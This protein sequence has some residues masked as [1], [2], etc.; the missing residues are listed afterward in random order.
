M[1]NFSRSQEWCSMWQH[2]A[3]R[4]DFDQPLF[5]LLKHGRRFREFGPTKGARDGGCWSVIGVHGWARV[6]VDHYERRDAWAKAVRLGLAV[7]VKQKHRVD[8]SQADRAPFQRRGSTAS[9]ITDA[10]S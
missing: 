1:R 9:R 10:R 8:R 4:I 5:Q 2:Q 3:G 7:A 6:H